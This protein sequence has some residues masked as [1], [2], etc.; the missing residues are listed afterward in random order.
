V[1]EGK[2]EQRG[3]RERDRK[4]ERMESGGGDETRQIDS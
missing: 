2:G 3:G 4:R 1:K